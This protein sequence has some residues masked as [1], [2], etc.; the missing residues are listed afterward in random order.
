M[1]FKSYNEGFRSEHI[2]NRTNKVELNN[3]IVQTVYFSLSFGN[4]IDELKV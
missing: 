2:V 1:C 4:P 3:A